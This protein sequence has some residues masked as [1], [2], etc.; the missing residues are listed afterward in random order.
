LR[1]GPFEVANPHRTADAGVV[2]KERTRVQ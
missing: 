1:G 2:G